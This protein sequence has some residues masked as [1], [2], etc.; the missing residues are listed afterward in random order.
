VLDAEQWAVL[1]QDGDNGRVICTMPS[2]DALA[3]AAASGGI[4]VDNGQGVSGGAVA[5]LGESAASIGLRTQSIQLLRDAMF[6]M[7]EAHANGAID[8]FELGIM[9]R[10][11]QSSMVAILA[12]EQLTG[13]VVA[14]PVAVSAVGEGTVLQ[15]LVRERDAVEAELSRNRAELARTGDAAPDPERKKELDA[16]NVVLE[17]NSEIYLNAISAITRGDFAAAELMVGSVSNRGEARDMAAVAATVESITLAAMG[18]QDNFHEEMCF[19][20][21]RRIALRREQPGADPYT[22]YCSQLATT[23]LAERAAV[24]QIVDRTL[25]AFL[26]DDDGLTREELATLDHMLAQIDRHWTRGDLRDFSTAPSPPAPP[27]PPPPQPRQG[28]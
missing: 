2:P 5:A 10:R 7:C 9:M 24:L 22:L 3:A 25:T 11:F 12:I 28:G 13:A 4:S 14:P 26:N 6:R 21:G 17:Q 18:T 19:E 23:N 16:R 8:D 1:N 15:A 27:P 20:M